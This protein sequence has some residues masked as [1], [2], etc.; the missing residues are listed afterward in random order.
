MI[1][2][3][4]RNMYTTTWTKYCCNFKAEKTRPQRPSSNKS[5]PTL[6]YVHLKRETRNCNCLDVT[7]PG[8]FLVSC[9]QRGKTATLIFSFVHPIVVCGVSNLEEWYHGTSQ[10]RAL[11]ASSLLERD[12]R[13]TEQKPFWLSPLRSTEPHISSMP[14][15]K[16]NSM[17]CWNAVK[18][19]ISERHVSNS[20]PVSSEPWES[21][22]E[23]EIVKV[24]K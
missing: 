22:Q 9:I 6:A 3:I 13:E 7:F 15:F 8:M 12:R 23:G 11:S 1:F 17:T 24:I 2:T 10:G 16:E 19:M 18:V 21:K 5:S 14:R 4:T 20:Q